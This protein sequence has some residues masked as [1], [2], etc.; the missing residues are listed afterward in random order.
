MNR[1]GDSSAFVI[2]AGQLLL[3][4]WGKTSANYLNSIQSPFNKSCQQGVVNSYQQQNEMHAEFCRK[5][6]LVSE[7][8]HGT[9]SKCENSEQE[10]YK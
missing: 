2:P 8:G 9:N 4:G 5:N 6:K 1:L 3:T 7:P 10:V